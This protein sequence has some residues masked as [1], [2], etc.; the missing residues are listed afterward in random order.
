MIAILKTGFFKEMVALLLKQLASTGTI[1]AG[2]RVWCG[3]A[4]HIAD[5]NAILGVWKHAA[6]KNYSRYKC[7]EIRFWTMLLCL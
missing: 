4:K 1:G 6:R 2:K 3:I 5:T 7:S